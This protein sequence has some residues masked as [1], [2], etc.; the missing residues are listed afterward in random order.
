M[1]QWYLDRASMRAYNVIIIYLNCGLEHKV[2]MICNNCSY[3]YCRSQGSN[4][5]YEFFRYPS[6]VA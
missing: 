2:E 4:P 5:V 3:H 1:A 6:S